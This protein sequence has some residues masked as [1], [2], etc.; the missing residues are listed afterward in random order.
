LPELYGTRH[1]GSIK[2]IASAFMVVGSAI[3][4]G[5]TGLVIDLGIDFSGQTI[6]MALATVGLSALHLTV[7]SRLPS[8][9]VTR[10]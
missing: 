10:S 9:S 7:V 2:A 3:G 5:L 1:L 6:A 4:P 8:R